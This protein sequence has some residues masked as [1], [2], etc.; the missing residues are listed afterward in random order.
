MITAILLR[1]K[2]LDKQDFSSLRYITS[3]G[4]TLPPKHIDFLRKAFPGVKIYSMYG[5]TECKRVAYLPPEQLE[6][7][8]GSVGKAMPNTETYI[9]DENDEVI[10]EA[11][12]PGE[13]VVRGSNIMRG[14]WNLPEETAKALRPGPYPGEKVLYTGDLFQ[15]DEQ[16]YLYFLGRKDDIIKT[17]GHM[18][19][20]KEVE[21]AL[22]EKE[23]VIEAAVIGMDDE[24]LGKAVQAFVHLT[25][26][27][28]STKEDIIK[29]CSERLEDFA[30]PKKVILCGP[31]PRTATGKIQKRELLAPKS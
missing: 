10:T 16:G 19:S 5:L 26:S 15:Q 14:Y 21:N 4:Q 22:C 29:F 18:V 30:V 24:I 1:L 7:R 12:K 25:N 2:N 9:V 17:A 27:S 28:H 20:P 6:N 13:I 31:L 3:T 8:P 11:G 23:D